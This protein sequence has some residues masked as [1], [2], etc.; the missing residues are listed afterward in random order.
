MDPTLLLFSYKPRFYISA[1]VNSKNNW[2]QSA[3]N[4]MLIHQV[5]LYD[6]YGST[7]RSVRQGFLSRLICEAVNSHQYVIHILTPFFW[8]LSDCEGNYEFFFT[9]T[10]QWFPQYI[11]LFVVF[12]GRAGIMAFSF[13]RSETVCFLYVGLVEDKL[14]SNNPCA[15]HNLKILIEEVTFFTV[16]SRTFMWNK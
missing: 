11:I 3:E 7:V 1:Y 10:V 14:L 16:I 13:T 9:R 2:Y 15:G 8:H 12:C 4:F 5:P 6:V